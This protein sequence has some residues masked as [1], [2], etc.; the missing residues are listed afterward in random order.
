MAAICSSIYD[1]ISELQAL[2]YTSRP[3]KAN[4]VRTKHSFVAVDKF[5]G[6]KIY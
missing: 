4:K 1:G 5:P 3:G 6:V 2:V